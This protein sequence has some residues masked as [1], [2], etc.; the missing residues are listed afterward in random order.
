MHGNCTLVTTL[1]QLELGILHVGT[2][3]LRRRNT[4]WIIALTRHITCIA[5]LCCSLAVA[6]ESTVD[7]RPGI[8]P[9]IRDDEIKLK[10]QRGN[11]VAVPIPISNPTLNEGLVAGAA[12]FYPQTEEEQKLQPASVTAA[13]GLY[14]S[15]DSKALA[16][17]QQNYWLENKWRFTGILGGADLRLSL[18]APDD[19]S[20]GK[21][22]D[23]RIEGTFLSAKIM[24]SI[25]PKWYGGVFT[26]YIDTTQ[27]IEA[28][29]TQSILSD[30]DTGVDIISVG[31]GAVIEYDSR[32]MPM[33][34]Y[35][36]K[37]FKIDALFNDESLGS[38]STYQSYSFAYRSYH[39]LSD[40]VVLAW[41]LQ[42]CSRGGSA[43]LWDAC[44][45][46]LRGFSATD[47]LGKV[48]TSTQAEA[49]WRL[50]PRWGVVGF[51]GVGYVGK[52]F[53]G[54][55]ERE[56]IPSYGVGIRF[57]VLPVKRINIRLDYARSVD[58]DA[59]HFSVGES[60]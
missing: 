43:P 44:T 30:L 14:T 16:L 28:T 18:L 17:V 13:A 9:D 48:S 45:V 54:I 29:D 7:T 40:S 38:N 42:G 59:I 23:W 5:L 46:K 53:S 8:A 10:V 51:A 58:S 34:S 37:H 6:E 22:V 50:S 41:E 25:R 52:S 26:R 32:D 47:Y 4:N 31:L 11:F 55:R 56:A 60:F 19:T 36:G 27:S 15:N 33:N 35:S 1:F 49:R 57:S 39:T 20:S 21:N 2:D 3:E 12:Y 24:R